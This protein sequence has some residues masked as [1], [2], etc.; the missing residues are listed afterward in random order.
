MLPIKAD[1]ISKSIEW[2]TKIDN[3]CQLSEI[4]PYL[5]PAIA[6]FVSGNA[7]EK[8]EEGD[9]F[10]SS[11]YQTAKIPEIDQLKSTE[12]EPFLKPEISRPLYE[13]FK[14]PSTYISKAKLQTVES[15]T[16]MFNFL[17]EEYNLQEQDITRLKVKFWTK[18]PWNIFLLLDNLTVDIERDRTNQNLQL[19]NPHPSLQRNSDAQEAPRKE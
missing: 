13:F 11:I 2:Y 18:F 9:S 10:I 14:D 6:N 19:T 8:I 5:N 7:S 1:Q 12:F 4:L 3:G 15:I 16:F 17:V